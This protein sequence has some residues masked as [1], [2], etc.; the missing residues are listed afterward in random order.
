MEKE[1]SGRT[2][3][4]AGGVWG[5]GN[6]LTEGVLCENE[7]RSEKRAF[8][9]RFLWFVFLCWRDNIFD[10][11]ASPSLSEC[12]IVWCRDGLSGDSLAFFNDNIGTEGSRYGFLYDMGG[13]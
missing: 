7:N 6:L 3:G 12:N 13:E 9:I 8:I 2:A 5:I 1:I 10:V 11:F 4:G